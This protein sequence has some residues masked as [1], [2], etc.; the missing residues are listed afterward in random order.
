MYIVYI[1]KVTTAYCPNYRPLP[2]PTIVA[3]VTTVRASAVV[4]GTP[5]LP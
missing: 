2:P 1:E 4:V 3:P 5:A